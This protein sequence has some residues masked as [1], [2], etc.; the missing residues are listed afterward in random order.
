LTSQ[1]APA[2]AEDI[3]RFANVATEKFRSIMDKKPELAERLNKQLDM[4]KQ[5]K[6]VRRSKEVLAGHAL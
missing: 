1:G 2:G 6:L 5:Q 4:G 3:I